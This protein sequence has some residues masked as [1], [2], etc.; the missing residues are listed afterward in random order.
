MVYRTTQSHRLA[1]QLAE[2]AFAAPQVV[3]QRTFRMASAGARPSRRDQAEFM[4]MGVEKIAAFYQSWSAMW[5]AGWSAP[6]ELAKASSSVPSV[7]SAASTSALDVLA[8]G[9][10][11]V[12]SRAVSNARRL[13]RASR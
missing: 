12:H 10:A 11:P 6:L 2:L 7:L 4:R 13:S 3:A 9:L 5:A 8:A 1:R